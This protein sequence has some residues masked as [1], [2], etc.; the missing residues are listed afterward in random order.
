MSRNLARYS[1]IIT[2]LWP[3][4]AS[5]TPYSCIGRLSP[6]VISNIA[7]LVPFA[8]A[9][10][11]SLAASVALLRGTTTTVV[12]HLLAGV[13]GAWVALFMAATQL[14]KTQ[15]GSGPLHDARLWTVLAGSIAAW[16]VAYLPA[17]AICRALA[18]RG[19][20]IRL[21]LAGMILVTTMIVT[22]A[23]QVR[24][25]SLVYHPPTFGWE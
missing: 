20:T 23:A 12:K 14:A 25:D 22:G 13:M 2:A 21:V 4:N 24:H 18:T 11:T 7:I 19:R 6:F 17:I 10:M 8:L 1:L 15:C 5:A 16:A 9:V 3:A